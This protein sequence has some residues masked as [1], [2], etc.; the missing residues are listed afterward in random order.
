MPD[1]TA[2]RPVT[3]TS[4]SL[5]DVG[6]VR[7]VNEDSVIESSEKNLWAI[8]DG[9]GGHQIGDVASQKVVAAL[10]KVY[11]SATLSE[12]V[13]VIEDALLS[14]NQ[15]LIDFAREHFDSQ[16]MG[17]TVVC[18]IIK[19]YV[20]VALWVGDSR[21]YRYRNH[22]LQ[23]MTRDHSQVEE[24]VQMGLITKEE[25][26]V[27]PHKNVITRAVGVEPNLFVDLNVFSTQVGDTFLLCSDGLYNSVSQENVETMLSHRDA[28]ACT[29]DLMKT[30]LDNGAE[31][32]VSLIVVK[33]EPGKLN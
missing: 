16:T 31:D 9:M 18:L 12:Y 7:E 28:E 14:A 10:E 20:G 13:D 17:T 24:M 8:A 29:L 23:Q 4:Y 19:E 5:S 33:G 2:R 6:C 15:E 3:W 11:P 21:L 27:H 22:Q 26:E 25:A 30:S 32:N 1:S